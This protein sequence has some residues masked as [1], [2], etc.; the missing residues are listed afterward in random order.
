M[1]LIKTSVLTTIST[2]IKILSGFLINKMMAIYIGPAGLA[3]VGQLQNFNT[4]VT[5][6]SNGAITQGVVKYVAE[7]D[8]LERKKG[9]F[10]TSVVVSLLCS[11]SI[12][13]ILFIFNLELSILILK[14]DEYASV[15]T[16]FS[17]T[18]VLFAL[19]TMLM[20][21]LNGQKEIKKY[22]Y[23]NIVN[24]LVILILTYLLIVELNI[25]G[26][27]YALVTGQSV[28]FF[29]TLFFVIKAKWFRWEYFLNGPDRKSLVKLSKFSLMALTSAITVPVS[30]IIIRNYIGENLSW[31][32][33]GYWLRVSIGMR[34]LLCS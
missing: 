9:I 10:S 7:Y 15:F 33:A 23:I 19:N 27:F 12:G 1:N 29:I 32:D 31:S 34:V 6:L 17:F 2:I 30:H 14:S 28:V 26:V 18:I 5:T 8:T 3:M 24:S 16:L 25:I 22:V 20:A 21:I 13:V 4:F 11:F